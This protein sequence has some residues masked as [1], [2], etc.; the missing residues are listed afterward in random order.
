[1]KRSIEIEKL[2]HW[3]YRD[4]LS[5]R[6]TSSAEGIWDHIQEFGANGGIDLGHGAAQRYPHFG[7]PH[8]DAEKIEK[9]V[10]A[11]EDQ[12][13]D[14]AAST[15]ALM[16]DLAP[17]LSQRDVLSVRSLRTT[18]L[19]T[20]HA[21]MGTRPDWH[22]ETPR[23]RWIEPEKGPQNRPRIIGE[24]RGRF[25]YTVGSYC[26]LQW[27]PSA[28][29]I[30]L[31][32]LDYVAWHRGLAQL[33]EVLEL[34]AH[35]ALPPAAKEQPWFDRTPPGRIFKFGEVTREKLPLKPQRDYAGPP[36]RRGRHGSVTTK[37]TNETSA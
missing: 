8:P 5:K 14:L 7:L 34:D 31:A 19:V 10:A 2:L 33:A 4:E 11:L 27:D 23:P 37:V 24:C 35:D 21:Y 29:S 36:P 1:M 12:C 26:P 28:I 6:Q 30:A 32:R 16:G 13:I 17:L 15:D 3:A 22:P 9:A 20:M 18:A 25:L